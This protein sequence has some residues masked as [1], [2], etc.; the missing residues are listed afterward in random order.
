MTSREDNVSEI[1]LLIA[2]NQLSLLCNIC[3][4]TQVELKAI[5]KIMENW[6]TTSIGA[7]YRS[8]APVF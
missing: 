3:M 4:C 6:K 8:S 7:H 5:F 1:L 2:G